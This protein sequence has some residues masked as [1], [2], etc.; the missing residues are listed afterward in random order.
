MI[1]KHIDDTILY[2]LK[3]HWTTTEDLTEHVAKRI[4]KISPDSEITILGITARLQTLQEEL[5]IHQIQFGKRDVWKLY[6]DYST[7]PNKIWQIITSLAKLECHIKHIIYTITKQDNSITSVQI[8][9]A[10]GILQSKGIIQVNNKVASVSSSE[11]QFILVR[12]AS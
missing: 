10:I 3:L 7:I 2:Q 8:R 1:V 12:Y 4:Q 9:N 6:G 5:K 11:K